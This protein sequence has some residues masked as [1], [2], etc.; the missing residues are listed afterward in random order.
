[1]NVQS[2]R[3]HDVMMYY[4]DSKSWFVHR[5]LEDLN[6]FHPILHEPISPNVLVYLQYLNDRPINKYWIILLNISLKLT[7]D[8]VCNIF[9]NACCRLIFPFSIDSILDRTLSI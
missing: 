2:H 3:V 9:V 6:H 4:Y 7:S 8:I 1:M 5:V